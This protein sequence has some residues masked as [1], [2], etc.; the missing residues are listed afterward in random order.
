V[1]DDGV[2]VVDLL[3][4]GVVAKQVEPVERVR[5]LADPAARH[6]EAADREVMPAHRVRK[7]GEESPVLVP[8]EPV[9]QHHQRARILRRVDVPAQRKAFGG[10]DGEV[11]VKAGDLLSKH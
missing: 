9:H 6:V 10:G 11:H 2:Q 7:P 5:I 3:R 8:L 4:V 1:P